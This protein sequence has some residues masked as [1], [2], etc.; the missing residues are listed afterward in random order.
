MAGMTVVAW[1]RDD[2]SRGH[3]IARRQRL[4][5]GWLFHGSEVL[6]GD[7]TLSCTFSVVVGPDWVT[8]HV[9]AL[10]V[11]ALG[12]ARLVL[13]AVDGE[14][15]VDGEPRP[16]LDGCV[17]V[18]IAATP[19]TNT[20]PIR[21]L[22]HLPIGEPVTSGVAWVDVPALGVAR[23]DQTYVRLEDRDGLACWRYSDPDHGAFVL[24]VDDEG[25]VVDYEGF[26]RRIPL[27]GDSR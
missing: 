18:D 2:E 5:D 23:V 4:D 6:V 10:S 20:F 27:A 9:E 21:R 7:D 3:S 8:R 12:E 19:L 22:A 13:D 11:S 1:E 15:T 26:A 16:D 24:T 25:L 17:D 14:W